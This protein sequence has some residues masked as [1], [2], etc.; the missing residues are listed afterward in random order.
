MLLLHFKNHSSIIWSLKF[1]HSG[2]FFL[3]SSADK[4]IKMWRTDIPAPIRVFAGH[5]ADVYKA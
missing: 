2:F 5:K 1:S 3:S 4:S